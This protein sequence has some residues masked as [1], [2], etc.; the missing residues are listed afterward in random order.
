[1]PNSRVSSTAANRFGPSGTLLRIP[2]TASIGFNTET[3][4]KAEYFRSEILASIEVYEEEE[5]DLDDDVTDIDTEALAGYD[6]DEGQEDLPFESDWLAQEHGIKVTDEDVRNTP[7]EVLAYQKGITEEDIDNPRQLLSRAAPLLAKFPDTPYLIL[8]VANLYFMTGKEL[9]GRR[10]MEKLERD[11]PENIELTVGSIM[12]HEDDTRFLKMA[13]ALPQPLDIQNHPAGTDGNYH[14][15]EFLHFEEMA[16]RSDLLNE[17]I[18]EARR[19]LDRLVQFG[20]L[21][22]D[23]EQG[24]VAIAAA[25]LEHL[26]YKIEKG[27]GQLPAPDANIFAKVSER[28]QAIL[29][30]S[31]VDVAEMTREYREQQELAATPVRN[32]EP[33]V[34]RNAPLPLRKW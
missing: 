11:F 6:T 4:K 24:A 22:G 34:G 18:D 27:E 9:K 26:D 32:L 25:Q 17:N 7:A 5:D 19:R 28:T 15:L 14:A 13:K 31:M 8:E 23:V 10:L 12:S 1:M 29:Q 16:I 2:N 21:H 33:K 3:H 20:F 30:Q